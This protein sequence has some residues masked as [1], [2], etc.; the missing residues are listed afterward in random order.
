MGSV[1]ILFSSVTTPLMAG[2][3]GVG[4]TG[5]GAFLETAGTETLKTSALTTSAVEDH[6]GAGVAGYVQYR[7]GDNGFVIGLDYWP[8]SIPLGS[9]SRTIDDK[10]TDADEGSNEVVN[11]V[12]AKT[13]QHVTAYIETPALGPMGLF[14][15]VGYAHA[16][17]ETTEDMGTGASYGNEDIYGP[18]IGIGFKGG[19]DQGLQLKFLVDYTEFDEVSFVGGGQDPTGASTI[20]AATDIYA[21]RFSV[22]YNF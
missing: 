20:K 13:S 2:S 3:L 22:G 6:A 5:I 9:S 19:T 10:T 8:G 15:K 21:A 12:S 17:V 18:L 7:F 16:L 14:A 11:N 4:V 1:A